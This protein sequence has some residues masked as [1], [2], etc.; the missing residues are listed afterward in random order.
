MQT[1]LSGLLHPLQPADSTHSITLCC[2]PQLDYNI[3]CAAKLLA[4]WR[5][6]L[7]R[8][9]W[10][11]D[12]DPIAR[13][14]NDL[15]PP[16]V[17]GRHRVTP[18]SQESLGQKRGRRELPARRAGGMIPFSKILQTSAFHS[19]FG[20]FRRADSKC[21]VRYQKS[22]FWPH[23]GVEHFWQFF[24]LSFLATLCGEFEVIWI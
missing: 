3:Q 8:G 20:R 7:L 16:R 2:L 19:F 17:V 14:P 22:I 23:W 24:F 18:S 5:L 10:L 1:D 13:M 12:S 11:A 4:P 6:G 21:L 9:T 15:T